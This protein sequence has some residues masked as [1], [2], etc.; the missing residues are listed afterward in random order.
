MV[1][2]IR[3]E[4]L[5]GGR[6]R[7]YI[8]TGLRQVIAADPP[9]EVGARWREAIAAQAGWHR[10]RLGL[11][12]VRMVRPLKLAA[13]TLAV[14]LAIIVC[15][16]LVSPSVALY[17]GSIPGLGPVFHVLRLDR[18]LWLAYELNFAVQV[19]REV[20]DGE[21]VFK[22]H[23]L[24]AD[25][26]RT[27]MDYEVQLPAELWSEVS[28]RAALPR[29]AWYVVLWDQWGKCYGWR[30]L[31]PSYADRVQAVGDTVVY[32]G[33][34]EFRLLE[35]QSRRMTAGL[36]VLRPELQSHSPEELMDASE[37][38]A[39]RLTFPVDFGPA[40][41]RSRVFYPNVSDEVDGVR[42]TLLEV[43]AGATA[44]KYRFTVQGLGSTSGE[45]PLRGGM[46]LAAGGGGWV[47]TMWHDSEFTVTIPTPFTGPGTSTLYL[48]AQRV[49]DL[50]L[51]LPLKNTPDEKPA[52]VGFSLG[53]LDLTLTG[54]KRS[55]DRLELAFSGEGPASQ[56]LGCSLLVAV[57]G[58]D[59]IVISVNKAKYRQSA[60]IYCPS[61]LPGIWLEV[62]IG[63]PDPEE[64]RI[65]GV[66]E[67]L[68]RWL[69]FTFEWP[70]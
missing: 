24:V 9:A 11:A 34:Q 10:G 5:G 31:F 67:S 60:T 58:G 55:G 59:E 57:P 6:R 44:T 14:S 29:Y 45:L 35:L 28:Q 69:E 13:A 8:E 51:V 33:N 16:S 70:R 37:R 23:G 48:E 68:S 19:N 7:R 64:L 50:D 46:E 15:A 47:Q 52:P 54:W 43:T 49:R 3:G 21:V 56:P 30:A 2:R 40:A 61:R 38:L 12:G 42:A 41:S 25:N 66:E 1:K 18:G 65:R 63:E 62:Q 4:R 32:R 17:A 53:G 27:V 20:T 26:I 36:F 39:M 22:V